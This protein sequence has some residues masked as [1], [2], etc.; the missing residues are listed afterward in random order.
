MRCR[1]KSWLVTVAVLAAAGALAAPARADGPASRTAPARTAPAPSTMRV[2]ATRWQAAAR[3]GPKAT[4]HAARG[5]R[6]VPLGT[7]TQS[8]TVV[9]R[10]GTAYVTSDEGT[11]SVVDVG[12]CNIRRAG[13][14][15]GP[16]AELSGPSDAIG[17]AT[18]GHTLYVTSGVSGTDGAV[19]V[20][21]T[22]HCYAADVSGCGAAVATVPVADI[23]TGVALDRSTAT[24]FVGNTADHVDLLALRSCR[25]ADTT[26]CGA[27]DVGSI[28]AKNGPVFP[29][30]DARDHTLYVPANG[31]GA[32]ASG[33]RVHV[34]DL[35]H[36]DAADTSGCAA[37]EASLRAGTGAV[38]A[39]V[40]HRTGTL[41]VANQTA[42]TV[43]VL[44]VR[45]CTGAHHAGCAQ[46]PKTISVGANPSGGI[47]ETSDRRLYVANS[48]SDT[49]STFS[50]RRCRASNTTGCPATPPTVRADGAPF[51]LDYD[52]DTQTI[53]SVEHAGQ[54]LGVLDAGLCS[55]TGR[56]CRHL[57]PSV[58]GN[59]QQLADPGLHTWYGVDGNG[60]LTLTDTR[61]CTAQHARRCAAAAIHTSRPNTSFGQ[62]VADNSTHSL[63][64]IR[65]NLKTGRGSL[66]VLDTRTCNAIAHTDCRPVVKP[67]PLPDY[68]AL[69]A[70]D[71]STHTVYV[72]TQYDSSLQVIDGTRCNA[73]RQTACSAPAGAVPLDGVAYGIAID[74]ATRTVYVSEFGN[75]DSDVVYAVDS[76]HCRATDVSGCAQTPKQFTSGLSPLGLVND[77]AHH[78][79]FVLANAGGDHEGQLDVFDTRTCSAR[80][81]SGCTPAAAFD[82]GRAPFTGA[83]DP[84]TGNLFVTDFEHAALT[85]IATGRCNATR[86]GGCH[87]RQFDVGDEP[88]QVAIDPQTH[89]VFVLGGLYTRTYYLDT[90][91]R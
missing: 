74:R 31:P 29:T 43:S 81:V 16:V 18:Y 77:P 48:N 63:Y 38:I 51:A 61:T 21:D 9:A 57:L 82:V 47:I 24:L 12:H 17:A 56:A 4:S 62:M 79:L 32:D 50:T 41:Y 91:V 53:F 40:D 36:C 8:L 3:R 89:S 22:S 78:T 72:T 88:T 76:T 14:C 7:A 66:V 85:V 49:L 19:S 27:A 73:V 2:A 35:R 11:V 6:A 15:A 34:V 90:R 46:T 1:S 65:N 75:F 59:R 42:A 37:P 30:L 55:G 13:S 67:M 69:I 20:Y 64:L 39:F 26:G 70:I 10:T 71:R 45:R 86:T 44:G 28:P 68:T 84:V 60:N 83:L 52:P 5:A 87:D 80:G 58:T 25:A 33:T 23:P 54:A